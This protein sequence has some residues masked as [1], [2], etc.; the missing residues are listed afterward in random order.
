MLAKEAQITRVTF[1]AHAARLS[2][3][4]AR[5]SLVETQIEDLCASLSDLHEDDVQRSIIALKQSQADLHAAVIDIREAQQ[6]L[7]R[8]LE[9]NRDAR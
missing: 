8:E 3:I 4:E 6:R 7:F 2:A 9:Q 5:L 1:A